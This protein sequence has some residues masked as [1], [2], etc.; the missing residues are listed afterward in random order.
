MTNRTIV[1]DISLGHREISLDACLKNLMWGLFDLS[2]NLSG[3]GRVEF[4]VRQ[5]K[6]NSEFKYRTFKTSLVRDLFIV[7]IRTRRQE[8]IVGELVAFEKS[9][10]KSEEQYVDGLDLDEINK[11][12]KT[13]TDS[14]KGSEKKPLSVEYTFSPTSLDQDLLALP[15]G[16]KRVFMDFLMPRFTEYLDR[17]EGVDDIYGFEDYKNMLDVISST[18]KRLQDQQDAEPIVIGGSSSNCLIASD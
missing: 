6:F 10:S 12:I 2:Q 17:F 9:L 8:T 7:K 16:L 14:I 11:S 13:I 1:E 18:N 3:C 4:S 5:E 15:E